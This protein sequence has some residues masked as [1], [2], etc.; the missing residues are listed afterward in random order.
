M[1]IYNTK[2]FHKLLTI[3]KYFSLINQQDNIKKISKTM[4]ILV[5]PHDL[6]FNITHN[7]HN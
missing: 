1:V 2:L 7:G 3:G 6:N 5:W 4:V